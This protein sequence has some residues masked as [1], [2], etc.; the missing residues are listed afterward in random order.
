MSH[1]I[2]WL[3]SKHQLTNYNIPTTWR[4]ARGGL[5]TFYEG[6]KRQTNAQCALTVIHTCIIRTTET[7]QIEM[8]TAQTRERKNGDLITREIFIENTSVK[9][10]NVTRK[11]QEVEG[12]WLPLFT[13][14]TL[15]GWGRRL[16]QWRRTQHRRIWKTR[17]GLDRFDEKTF[18]GRTFSKA[19]RLN[20]NRDQSEPNKL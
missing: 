20:S 16:G 11:L 12:E 9:N 17:H 13:S 3:G 8:T 4:W 6:N 2:R 7:R 14:C 15:W 18:K 5:L 19:T 1:N 10:E